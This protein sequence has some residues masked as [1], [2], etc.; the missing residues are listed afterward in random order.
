MINRFALMTF[1][2]VPFV[3]LA[4]L[5]PDLPAQIP[6]HFDW[7]GQPDAWGPKYILWII[8][9]VGVLVTLLVDLAVRKAAAVGGS[10][11]KH[12]NV[13]YLTLTFTTAILCYIFHGTQAGGFDGLGGVSVLLG[14]LFAGLGNYLPILGLNRYI[15][16]RVP[17]TLRSETNWRKTH[18]FAGPLFLFGG[19][20][21][22]LNGVLLR[23][24]VE[25]FVML[26]IVAVLAVVPIIYAYQLPDDPEGDYV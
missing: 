21:L 3:Y 22:V 16:I 5:Y 15:G 24:G 14:L 11:R 26:G 17:P 18:R 25:T 23:N 19:L 2:A 8:P 12:R 6:L 4:T 10:E 1:A 20:A 13:G 7:R 9:F